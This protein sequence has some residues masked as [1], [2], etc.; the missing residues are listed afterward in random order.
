[1]KILNRFKIVFLSVFLVFSFAFPCFAQTEQWIEDYNFPEFPATI[2]P[3]WNNPCTDYLIYYCQSKGRYILMCQSGSGDR[4]KINTDGCIVTGSDPY[5]SYYYWIPS[6][7]SS[8]NYLWVTSSDN[9]YYDSYPGTSSDLVYS[10]FNVL[11]STGEV[12]FFATPSPT[13]IMT[14]MY[15]SDLVQTL[16][17]ALKLGLIIVVSWLVFQ[18][19]FKVFL[20]VL[21]NFRLR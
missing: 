8:W 5:T 2:H 19:G 21:Q 10:S 20:R 1:M 14:S 4:A 7:N 16:Q 11:D 17:Q 15:G 18:A 6:T 9:L 3:S 12:S 13:S